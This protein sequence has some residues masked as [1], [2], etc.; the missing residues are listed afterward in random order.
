MPPEHLVFKT[1]SETDTF[2]EADWIDTCTNNKG[3]IHTQNKGLTRR[4]LSVENRVDYL[5]IPQELSTN[6]LIYYP[7]SMIAV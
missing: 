7:M 4:N 1:E 3:E 2:I 5:N 6:I